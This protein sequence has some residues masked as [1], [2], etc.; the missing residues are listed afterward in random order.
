MTSPLL[1]L[2]GYAAT[3]SDWDRGVGANPL[4]GLEGPLTSK[5]WPPMAQEPERLAALIASVAA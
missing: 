1:P 3:G 5:P 2:N 4:D